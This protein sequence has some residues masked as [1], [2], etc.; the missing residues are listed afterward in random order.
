MMSYFTKYKKLDLVE[1]VD[2]SKLS[3]IR[4]EVKLSSGL[5]K[6]GHFYFR[7][8][9]NYVY[10][11]L[12]GP[13]SFSNEKDWK[14]FNEVTLPHELYT[15]NT[16]YADKFPQLIE[17]LSDFAK[18][19]NACLS[20]VFLAK[21]KDNAVPYRHVDLGFFYMFHH[22]YHLVIDSSQGSEMES[23][24]LKKIFFSGDV[25]SINNKIPHTGMN[26]KEGGER[27][28]VFFDILPKNPL[29]L[30]RMYLQ[31]LFVYRPIR[32]FY[33]YSFLK[34]LFGIIYLMEAIL[35]GFFAYPNESNT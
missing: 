7:G 13:Y 14:H 29:T 3:H 31:W 19:N 26:H 6:R 24:D 15:T 32:G 28:H 23:G 8:T 12:R 22:R 1:R 17:Y 4:E 30:T 10:L 11:H 18:K 33:N 21:I 5:M 9:D 20:R 34:G 27:V 35:L 25:F 16:Q 2:D